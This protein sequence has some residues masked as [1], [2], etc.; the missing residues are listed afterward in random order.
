MKIELTD[1]EAKTLKFYLEQSLIDAR[2]LC[3][4]GVGNKNSVINL[5]SII[6]KINNIKW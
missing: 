3:A 1:S 4:I 5:E 6:K 2:G